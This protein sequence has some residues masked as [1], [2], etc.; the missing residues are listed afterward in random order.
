[1]GTW[2]FEEREGRMKVGEPPCRKKRTE[3]EK[4]KGGISMARP[5]KV[6]RTWNLGNWV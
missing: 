4:K 6:D 5:E 3:E 1:M 2:Q